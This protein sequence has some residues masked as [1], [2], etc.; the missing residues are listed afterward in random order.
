MTIVLPIRASLR[1]SPGRFVHRIS[2]LERAV[3]DTAL[4]T[5]IYHPIFL[6]SFWAV[7]LWV[8]L[9]TKVSDKGSSGL[10][11]WGNRQLFNKHDTLTNSAQFGEWFCGYRD[12]DVT[13]AIG[14]PQS[15]EMDARN[16]RVAILVEKER[17]TADFYDI[18]D[19]KYLPITSSRPSC[20]R[21]CVAH[22]LG[23]MWLVQIVAYQQQVH[24]DEIIISALRP[25]GGPDLCEGVWSEERIIC[26]RTMLFSRWDQS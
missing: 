4:R 3:S 20:R 14:K 26:T 18:W 1:V 9:H 7:L 10:Q 16:L 12:R 5:A 23:N 6:A 25:N 2:W 17:T 22:F 8:L 24:G 19:G 15:G 21:A 13:F 11:W